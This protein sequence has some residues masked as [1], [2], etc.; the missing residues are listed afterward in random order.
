MED[1]TGSEN[2][3]SLVGDEAD[4]VDSDDYSISE[5]EPPSQHHELAERSTDGEDDQS[6]INGS[7][8]RCITESDQ[9]D[10]ESNSSED[11]D[12]TDIEEIEELELPIENVELA[13]E[14][15]GRMWP[16]ETD[17]PH[18][19][20]SS[21]QFFSLDII[22]ER[23]MKIFAF[24][25]IISVLFMGVFFGDVFGIQ[26]LR[27]S[28]DSETFSEPIRLGDP[29]L[30]FEPIFEKP[31][32]AHEDEME[33]EDKDELD[34]CHQNL[35]DVVKQASLNSVLMRYMRSKTSRLETLIQE[36]QTFVDIQRQEIQSLQQANE[37]KTPLQSESLTE[38]ALTN[39]LPC[40]DS[41]ENVVH[42]T[43]QPSSELPSPSFLPD[44]EFLEP[45][46][47]TCTQNERSFFNL[48]RTFLN[49]MAMMA[50][51]TALTLFVDSRPELARFTNWLQ[52]QTLK[53]F[54]RMVE[55]VK[56]GWQFKFRS[57]MQ[58][59]SNALS[60]PAITSLTKPKNMVG[61]IKRKI[62][63]VFNKLSQSKWLKVDEEEVCVSNSTCDLL[64]EFGNYLAEDKIF[65][66][67]LTPKQADSYVTF[68][69]HIPTRQCTANSTLVSCERCFWVGKCEGIQK[70]CN[71]RRW[72]RQRKID[73]KQFIDG[74][75]KVKEIFKT[76][77]WLELQDLTA[78]PLI[79]P[80]PI[81]PPRSKKS[82]KNEKSCKEN[83]VT[84]RGA[85]R[86][87]H[88]RRASA[89]SWFFDRQAQRKALRQKD[90]ASDWFF[91]R[92]QKRAAL[93]TP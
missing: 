23:R 83:W 10:R 42:P 54:P 50:N 69:K 37:E 22:V 76:L 68:L 82:N 13:N 87:E 34:Q 7:E 84:R 81:G 85:T 14:S 24:A 8:Y 49:K 77:G 86:S 55:N 31:L 5:S 62:K 30:T 15:V 32:W 6:N 60:S 41:S 80:M 47:E 66:A 72:Q 45:Q 75:N 57:Y 74:S 91:D 20:E 56:S 33:I 26:Q 79:E 3:W 17:F 11:T 92:G 43:N 63:S 64:M 16:R 27:P 93:R 73:P 88:R 12:M 65:H 70:Q 48:T 61:T 71:Q 90:Q 19:C 78:M 46:F 1:G 59:V 89:N 53:A 67:N 9:S 35:N 2:S 40:V 25:T 28:Q 39:E 36:L 38:N 58:K 44:D 52:N 29:I 21:D 51:S 18:L 4:L